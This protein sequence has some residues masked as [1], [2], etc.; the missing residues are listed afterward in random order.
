MDTREATYAG[1][2]SDGAPIRRPMSPH[3]QV[4]DNLLMSTSLSI[5]HRITGVIVGV[6]TLL[7]VCW[8]AAAASGP[9]AYD[10][11]AWFMGS[12]LGY[13]MLFGWSGT[14]FFHLLNGIRHL[15][16]DVGY[17]F[18]IREM[19]ATGWS[20]LTGTAVLTVLVWIIYLIVG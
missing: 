17:G 15:A 5:S 4:W 18:E 1:L 20:V 6:A 14:L 10:S 3:L 13:L 2:T 19:Y 9:A 16:W 7:F 12:W 11:V 8:L